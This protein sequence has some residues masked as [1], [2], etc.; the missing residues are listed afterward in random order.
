M[1]Y[2]LYICIMSKN[3][4]NKNLINQ[5]SLDRLEHELKMKAMFPGLTKA[6]LEYWTRDKLIE[7]GNEQDKPK[8]N[9]SKEASR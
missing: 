6:L 9:K 4:W 3:K 1:D 5:T 8:K 7:L 2:F